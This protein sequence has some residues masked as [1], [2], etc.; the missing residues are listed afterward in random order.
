MTEAMQHFI[1]EH[2]CTLDYHIR[3][4]L[5]QPNFELTDDERED[6]INNDESLYNWARGEGALDED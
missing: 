4:A 2:R 3:G 6:W 1:D 5:H